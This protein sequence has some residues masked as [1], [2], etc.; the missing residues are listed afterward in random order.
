MGILAYGT[1]NPPTS[2]VDPAKEHLPALEPTLWSR[3]LTVE[4]G[5]CLESQSRIQGHID[6][7]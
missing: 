5:S 6:E 4:A 7:R 2:S 1:L 3:D